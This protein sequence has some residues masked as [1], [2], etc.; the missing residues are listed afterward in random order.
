MVTPKFIGE[1]TLREIHL[2]SARLFRRALEYFKA[3]EA[4]GAE[5]KLPFCNE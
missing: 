3:I 5:Y 4:M 2:K 1:N